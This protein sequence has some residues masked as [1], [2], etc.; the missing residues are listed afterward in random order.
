M[1]ASECIQ[2]RPALWPRAAA[3]LC[4]AVL[5]VSARAWFESSEVGAR[6]LSLGQSFVSVADDA[7]T[8]YWNPAGLVQL[9]RHEALLSY[10]QPVDLD[11]LRAG[12]AALVL[13][14]VPLSFGLGWQHTGLEDA[15]R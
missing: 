10:D 7:S 13:H 2:R 1:S 8:V 4:L 9:P 14:T 12:F 6:A 15:S 3:A 5:P 11:G